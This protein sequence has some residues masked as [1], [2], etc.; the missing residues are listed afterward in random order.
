MHPNV[1]LVTREIIGAA[2]EVHRILGP[3]FLESFYDNAL[4]A[5]LTARRI[6]FV[7]QVR[8]AVT[9]KGATVGR[10]RVDFIVAET[11]VVELKAVEHFAGI[12]TAQGISYLK[13]SGLQVA[14]LINF[15]V[16]R[17][18]NGLKRIALDQR[19]PHPS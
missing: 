15:N 10:A 2:L 3:G 19:Q 12:H 8:L 13:A 5:E 14:L 6:P 7:R 11:V 4:A 1:D 9:Y 16:Q 18:E 17:L